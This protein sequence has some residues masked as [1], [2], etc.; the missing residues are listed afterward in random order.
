MRP[1][2]GADRI[3]VG[4]E[5][6]YP[7]RPAPRTPRAPS[8][9]ARRPL[10]PGPDP[11]AGSD[12]VTKGTL[13]PMPTVSVPQYDDPELTI[14]DLLEADQDAAEEIDAGALEAIDTAI[15]CERLVTRLETL[16]AKA[17]DLEVPGRLIDDLR[18]LIDQAQ[19]V[20]AHAMALANRLPAAAEAVRAAAGA[21]EAH[22]P[23]ADITRDYGHNRPAKAEYHDD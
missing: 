13:M 17:E 9:T 20:R 11:D 2:P 15:A 23:T 8:Y 7:D 3:W 19:T 18:R 10:L 12:P 4:A 14:Y 6:I 5:R 21:A 16:I 22:K 1:P